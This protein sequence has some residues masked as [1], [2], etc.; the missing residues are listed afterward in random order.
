MLSY[1]LKH[2]SA[3][4]T[5]KNLWGQPFNVTGSFKVNQSSLSKMPRLSIY[6]GM[7][8]TNIVSNYH[9]SKWFKKT[10]NFIKQNILKK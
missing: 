6:D 3:V 8:V 9:S 2:N 4:H 5:R 10:A 7:N 1:K